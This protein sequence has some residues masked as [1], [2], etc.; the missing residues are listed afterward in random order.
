MHDVTWAQRPDQGQSVGGAFIMLISS[1]LL[2]GYEKLTET[3]PDLAQ[4]TTLRM[5]PTILQL[6]VWPAERSFQDLIIYSNC[7]STYL[8]CVYT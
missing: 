1:H 6:G 8:L 2:I 3:T 4:N 7:Y 5:V